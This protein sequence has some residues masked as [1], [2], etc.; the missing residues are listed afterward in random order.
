ML[1]SKEGNVPFHYEPEGCRVPG[2]T[3]TS[4][5]TASIRAMMATLIWGPSL[6]IQIMSW[7]KAPVVSAIISVIF[8]ILAVG[9]AKFIVEFRRNKPSEVKGFATL[10]LSWFALVCCVALILG[11]LLQFFANPTLLGIIIPLAGIVLCSA[12]VTVLW[13]NLKRYVLKK[14][15]AGSAERS[16]RE[17]PH[18]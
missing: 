6:L 3:N 14:G 9:V 5:D 8:I 17:D 11:S 10:G 18:Q 13:F 16:E 7:V 12:P 15:K 1:S 4:M 2:Q